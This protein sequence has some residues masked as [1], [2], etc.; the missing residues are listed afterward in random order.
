MGTISFMKTVLIYPKQLRHC[1]WKGTFLLNFYTILFFNLKPARFPEREETK[2]VFIVI[3]VSRPLSASCLYQYA[4]KPAASTSQAFSV[5]GAE[6]CQSQEWLILY[7]LIL[8]STSVLQFSALEQ[9]MLWNGFHS[10]KCTDLSDSFSRLC[11]WSVSHAINS[12]SNTISCPSGGRS[13][14]GRW[15]QSWK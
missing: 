5:K 7:E 4:K 11:L 2:Y 9:C 10:H 12:N 8:Y 6:L 1:F 3:W 13:V 14:I 15:D